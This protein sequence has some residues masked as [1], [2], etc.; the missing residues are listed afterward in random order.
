MLTR[1]HF[2]SLEIQQSPIGHIARSLAL[3]GAGKQEVTFDDF[4]FVFRDGDPDDIILLLVIKVCSTYS[5]YYDQNLFYLV[6]THVH[7]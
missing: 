5:M 6:Y 7:V 3:V 2:K 4:D 1:F